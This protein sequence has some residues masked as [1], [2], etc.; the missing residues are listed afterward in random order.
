MEQSGIQV[1]KGVLR[2]CFYPPYTC[3]FH[4]F[5]ASDIGASAISGL[6]WYY[7]L[8]VILPSLVKVLLSDAKLSIN[9]EPTKFFS[10][11]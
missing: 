11:K 8:F 1:F 5:S 4:R 9:F 6:H 10:V 3:E 2:G 7:Q